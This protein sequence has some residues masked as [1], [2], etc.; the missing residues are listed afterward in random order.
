M[1]IPIGA[2]SDLS[3]CGAALNGPTDCVIRWSSVQWCIVERGRGEDASVGDCEGALAT[4]AGGG[5]AS[6]S[7]SRRE[8]VT[9]PR[10]RFFGRGEGGR[11]IRMQ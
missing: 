9:E 2:V 11:S 4:Y 7:E 10:V 6:V 1:P 3:R 8:I 5:E